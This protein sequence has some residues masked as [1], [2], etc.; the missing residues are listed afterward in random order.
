M[1]RRPNEKH[2]SNFW[3]PDLE[4]KAKGRAQLLRM[5]DALVEHYN[6]G[7]F[8]SLV[9]TLA[10]NCSN[11]VKVV[12]DLEVPQ[13][14]DDG[15]T[16]TTYHDT[17]ITNTCR[18]VTYVDQEK[19]SSSIALIW[20]VL[21]TI[22]PDG[23]MKLVDKRIC[24][25]P[26]RSRYWSLGVQAG[27]VSPVSPARVM[28]VVVELYASCTV[29]WSLQHMLVLAIDA[30][31]QCLE[32]T[33]GDGASATSIADEPELQGFRSN[34]RTANSTPDDTPITCKRVQQHGSAAT[35]SLQILAGLVATYTGVAPHDRLASWSNG[36]VCA[37]R[38]TTENRKWRY[39]I[40]LRLQFDEHDLVTHWTTTMLAAEPDPVRDCV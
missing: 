25:R 8:D 30:T 11:E 19:S 29:L 17:A 13:S 28:E 32:L 31:R 37:V 1:I 10:A 40:E 35:A 38:G 4:N 24:Y 3:S 23:V 5:M 39:L 21:H 34:L 12:T 33:S 15:N 36:T 26:N 6:T 20:M 16:S 7:D 27:H 14:T 18:N 2:A 22:Y 9:I